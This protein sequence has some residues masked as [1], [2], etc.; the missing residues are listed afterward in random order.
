MAK[1]TLTL[2][3]HQVPFGWLAFLAMLRSVGFP[4]EPWGDTEGFSV[5]DRQEQMCISRGSQAAAS[6]LHP[7]G[8]PWRLETGGDY[9]VI[10]M[11]WA[12]LTAIRGKREG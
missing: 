3:G 11:A 4:R 7:R 12:K 5:G 8:A 6:A 10:I 9:R 2:C 1:V